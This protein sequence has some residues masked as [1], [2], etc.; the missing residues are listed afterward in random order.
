MGIP[1]DTKVQKKYLSTDGE[2]LNK[3]KATPSKML[4]KIQGLTEALDKVGL[5]N[6]DIA[7][8]IKDELKSIAQ[9]RGH[10]NPFVAIKAA[11]VTVKILDAV[12]KLKGNY[13]KG[14]SKGLDDESV[15]EMILGLK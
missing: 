3:I 10:T 15:D 4:K 9:F 11:E 12:C 2:L 14:K 6:P 1:R 8:I 7:K 13:E 5:A